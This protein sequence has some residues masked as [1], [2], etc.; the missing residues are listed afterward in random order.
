VFLNLFFSRLKGACERTK[1]NQLQKN[2]HNTTSE[3]SVEGISV[4]GTTHGTDMPAVL[5]QC[6]GYFLVPFFSTLGFRRQGS[7]VIR[8][9][10]KLRI[11]KSAGGMPAPRRANDRQLTGGGLW[12][13]VHQQAGK[14]AGECLYPKRV[15]TSCKWR[16]DGINSTS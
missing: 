5:S 10:N 15:H 8:S 1:Q 11:L 6:L 14:P 7:K 4:S 12:T 2:Q 13:G 16:V 3:G 9:I